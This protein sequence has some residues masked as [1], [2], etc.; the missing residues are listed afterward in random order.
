MTVC[1]CLEAAACGAA[2]ADTGV[3]TGRS[4]TG[5][6]PFVTA[7]VLCFAFSSSIRFSATVCRCLSCF[8]A[9]PCFLVAFSST[10]P[11]LKSDTF[12]CIWLTPLCTAYC[13][14]VGISFTCCLTD[15]ALSL[16]RS[17]LSRTAPTFA[18]ARFP[19]L[20]VSELWVSWFGLLWFPVSALR[21][22]EAI[23]APATPP[24]AP[25]ATVLPIFLSNRLA[26]RLRNI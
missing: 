26:L 11:R 5:A 23:A 3:V 18:P 17:L 19:K 7:R 6:V 9:R 2:F 1:S 20:E 8:S 4:C 21:L 22:L 16:I 13:A 15:C 14:C 10:M 12:S 24:A 25:A